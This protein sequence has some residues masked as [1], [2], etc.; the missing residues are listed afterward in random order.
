MKKLLIAR[1]LSL[2]VLM[3]GFTAAF[4]QTNISGDVAGTII[5]PTGAAVAHAAVTI[6][7]SE[8][9][10]IKTA[11]ANNVGNYRVPFL[12]PGKYTFSATASGFTP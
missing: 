10:E 4:A 12:K 1:V 7:S 11:V 5:D 3:V 2:F 6:T 9:G 8:N